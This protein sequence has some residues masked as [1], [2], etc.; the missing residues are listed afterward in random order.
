VDRNSLHLV[1]ASS[2]HGGAEEGREERPVSERQVKEKRTTRGMLVPVI[3]ETPSELSPPMGLSDLG[4]NATERGPP[5]RSAGCT[6][7]FGKKK[8]IWDPNLKHR[9]SEMG[10]ARTNLHC[11]IREDDEGEL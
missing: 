6:A 8:S 7:G 3:A 11:W 4:H 10:E 9:R 5:C 1:P 2:T